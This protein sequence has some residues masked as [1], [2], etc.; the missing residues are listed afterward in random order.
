MVLT[1]NLTS[2]NIFDFS[3]YRTYVTIIDFNVTACVQNQVAVRHRPVVRWSVG[4]TDTGQ[5]GRTDIQ[6]YN[7]FAVQRAEERRSVL[8]RI[9]R[10]TVF[11]YDW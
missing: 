3:A 6:L 7:S 4:E 8:V 11:I 9:A 5:C 1:T 10:P 2:P